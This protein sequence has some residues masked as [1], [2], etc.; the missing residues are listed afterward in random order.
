MTGALRTSGYDDYA[1]EYAAYVAWREQTG[2]EGAGRTT[3]LARRG[4]AFA[5][6]GSTATPS[7]TLT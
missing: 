7:P 2:P 5:R 1:A 4:S 3:S 6:S